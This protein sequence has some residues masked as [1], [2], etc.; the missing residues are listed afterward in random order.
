MINQGLK[1]CSEW[2]IHGCYVTQIEFHHLAFKI[3]LKFLNIS[4]RLSLDLFIFSLY[5]EEDLTL[6]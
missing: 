6:T 5:A 4:A 3:A 2:I 1:K